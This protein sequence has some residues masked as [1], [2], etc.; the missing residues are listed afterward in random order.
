MWAVHLMAEDTAKVGPF[1]FLSDAKSNAWF[2][3]VL[4][5][6]GT[7]RHLFGF[8]R[9]LATW[10]AAMAC[11]AYPLMALMAV[12]AMPGP[13]TLLVLLVQAFHS[14]C[15]ASHPNSPALL[16]SLVG[17]TSHCMHNW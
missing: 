6:L 9:L 12:G 15:A 4:L 7:P 10:C 16:G 11:Q 17:M 5:S 13:F 2:P 1:R 8:Y 3:F 14:V